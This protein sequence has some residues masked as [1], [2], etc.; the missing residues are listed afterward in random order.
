MVDQGAGADHASEQSIGR[1]HA[2]RAAEATAAPG[3]GLRHPGCR[4]R[5]LRRTDVRAGSHQGA[6]GLRS[7]GSSDLLLELLQDPVA[8]C[9]HR[10][11]DCRQVSAGNP[12]FA[13][14][15][16]PFGVQRH[17]NGHCRLSGKR[18]L[19][20]AFAFHPPGISQEPQRLPVGGAAIF[21]RRHANDAAYRRL[22]FVG[23][24]AGKG[25]YPG[26]ACARTAAG[27]QHCAG[28]DFQ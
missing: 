24:P 27:H 7:A 18:R 1:H 6:Q 13:D 10:L 12:A 15:Q 28:A 2:R 26:I 20:S 11:D 21:P 8:G 23:E 25:Q 17:A 5:Y 3:V 16:H 9:A 19:R 22:H 14:F 4:G